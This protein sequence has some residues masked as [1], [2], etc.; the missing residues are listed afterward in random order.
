MSKIRD[1]TNK[2]LDNKAFYV[3]LSIVLSVA[4]WIF[5]TGSVNP[6]REV[7]LTLDIEYV[8]L[9]VLENHNLRLSAD[10]PNTI[11]MRVEASVMDLNR[12]EQNSRII[13]DVSGIHEPGEYNVTFTLAAFNQLTGGVTLTPARSDLSNTSNTIIVR[14]NRITGQEFT[15]SDAGVLYDVDPDAGENYFFVGQRPI[16]EPEAIRVDGPEEILSAIG[17]I[18][19]WAQFSEPLRET[20]TQA[21]QFRVF[22]VYGN[23]L[24]E[25]DLRDVE[26]S[27]D[28]VHATVVVQMVKDVPLMPV[29]EY[30]GGVAEQNLRYTLSRDTVQLIGDPEVLRSVEEVVLPTVRLDQVGMRERVLRN[31]PTP[32]LVSIHDGGN[33]VEI[34]IQLINLEERRMSIPAN[35][36][37]LI[38]YAEDMIAEVVFEQFEVTIRGAASVLEQLD[39]SDI[40]ILV[41]LAEYTGTGHFN[42]EDFIVEVGNF[43][44]EVV[45][46]LDPG[47]II[48]S[49]QQR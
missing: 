45:G 35:Q 21:G 16:L 20:T 49:I 25:Y 4:I 24:S 26:F 41:N 33:D 17:R 9:G 43:D 46:A 6:T 8:G 14:T 7:P 10:Q 37:V 31:I 18:E 47:R 30:G 42:V 29:F 32:P 44:P 22:D 13:V 2:L 23:E 1:I 3:L 11:V 28:T 27:Q 39:E 36:I 34:D 38:G 12:L 15:L 48:I 19:V 40:S 5:V